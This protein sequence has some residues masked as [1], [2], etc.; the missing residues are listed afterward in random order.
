MTRG[1][2]VLRSINGGLTATTGLLCLLPVL[3]LAMVGCAVPPPITAEPSLPQGLATDEWAVFDGAWF[4]IRYP[5]GFIAK[6]SMPSADGGG[7]FDSAFFVSP[8]RRVGFYVLSPLWRRQA[9][10]IALQPEVEFEVDSTVMESDNPL[11]VVR[12]IAALDGSYRRR[13]ETFVS[14]D[15]TLSWSFQLHYVDDDAR[16]EWDSAYRRFKRSLEQYAD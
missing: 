6:P 14:R 7:G 11:L 3:S 15:K 9:I 2:P 8:D 1:L 10:D 5:P 13:V 16:Q 4:R 12:H